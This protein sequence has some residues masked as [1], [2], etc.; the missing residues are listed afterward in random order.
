VTVEGPESELSKI[1]YAKGI[2][3]PGALMYSTQFNTTV[4]LYDTGDNK[5]NNSYMNLKDTSVIVKLP[6]YKTVNLP[7]KVYFVGGYFSTESATIVYSDDYITVKG[8]VEDFE[9]LTEIKMNIAENTLVSGTTIE[10]D[11]ILPEGIECVSGQKKVSATITF[12]GLVIRSV[13]ASCSAVCD[14]INA[15]AN[16]DITVVTANL[17]VNF[18]GPVAGLMDLTQNS[19]RAIVDL[20]DMTLETGKTYNVPITINLIGSVNGMLSGAFPSG[21]YSVTISVNSKGE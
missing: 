3:Q 1:S 7:V 16:M 13:A 5:I 10:K 19:F 20:A 14:I 2:V 4:E 8:L 17:N 11:I 18:M 15:P 12:K 6:V 9:G 21:D